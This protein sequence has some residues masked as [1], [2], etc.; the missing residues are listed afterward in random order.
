MNLI[1][2]VKHFVRYDSRGK[3]LPKGQIRYDYDTEFIFTYNNH[4]L[5]LQGSSWKKPCE[6]EEVA[7]VLQAYFHG[8][9]YHLID[10]IKQLE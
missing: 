8:S 3:V 10:V 2:E 4:V 7:D 1:V 6:P 5:G 9:N